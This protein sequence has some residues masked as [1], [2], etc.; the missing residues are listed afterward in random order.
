MPKESRESFRL[1]AQN[2]IIPQ[3]LSLKL[4]KMIG[5]RNI[6]VHEYQQLNIE[7]MIDVVENR[8][9]DLVDFTNLIIKE[10]A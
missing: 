6:L 1:L 7:L 10:F 2:K 5:F 9:D 4:E 8:L 3:D